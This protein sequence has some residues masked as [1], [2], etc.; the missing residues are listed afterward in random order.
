MTPTPDLSIIFINWRM[1]HDLA[2]VFP[3]IE[4]QV[5]RYSTEVI[6]VNKHS[7]DGAEQ[8][9]AQYPFVRVIPHEQFGI[10]EMRNVGIRA[11][12]GRY[13]LML[14][15]DTEVHAGC[16]DALV[17]FMDKYPRIAAA[18]G[19][20]RRLNGE[21]E[22]NVKRFYTLM[23]IIARRSPIQT[24]NP[25]HRWNRAHLMMDKDHRRPYLGDWVAGACFCMRREAIEQV[26]LFD[27]RYY[28]GFEDLD[29]CWRAKRL[30][31]R[32]GFVPTARIT[33][34]VQRKSAQG[35]NRL[36]VEHLLSGLRFLWKKT[37]MDWGFPDDTVRLP[38]RAK[39]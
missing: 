34:K 16:F 36:T 27:D 33:H 1:A 25:N 23:T 7:E 28:F 3:S 2:H 39:R 32:I 31:W 14:D 22:H 38:E 15:A 11:A 24:F 29:W 13:C 18:G 30:G 5:T 17:S 10:A 35:L 6:L 37:K 26:G 21:L 9:A 19:H 12:R 20:T 8:I 4:R